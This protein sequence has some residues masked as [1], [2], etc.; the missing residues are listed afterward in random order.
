MKSPGTQLGQLI[1]GVDPGAVAI[2]CEHKRHGVTADQSSVGDRDR[3]WTF[4][5]Q[6]GLLDAVGFPTARTLAS[7]PQIRRR[8]LDGRPVVPR[9]DQAGAVLYFD[10]LRNF[11]KT[12]GYRPAGSKETPA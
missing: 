11:H 5:Y 4:N 3:L 6:A 1:E 7:R 10:P 12:A 9:H 2:R 8:K